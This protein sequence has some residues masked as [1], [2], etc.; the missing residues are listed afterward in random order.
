MLRLY[1]PIDPLQGPCKFGRVFGNIGEGFRTFGAGFEG[2]VGEG[3]WMFVRRV[4]RDLSSRAV[5]SADFV[6]ILAPAYVF[7]FHVNIQSLYS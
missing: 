3:F 1:I 5:G 2:F 7:H 6:R 4:L